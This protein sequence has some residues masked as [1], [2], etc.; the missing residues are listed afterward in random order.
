MRVGPLVLVRGEVVRRVGRERRRARQAAERRLRGRERGTLHS[1]SSIVRMI[2]AALIDRKGAF[3]PED[4]RCIAGHL[5]R[6][7]G[8]QDLRGGLP[9]HTAGFDLGSWVAEGSRALAA[10]L[11]AE[12]ALALVCANLRTCVFGAEITHAIHRDGA[13]F[14]VD[15]FT[16]AEAADTIAL[17]GTTRRRARA[18]CVV[19]VICGHSG[20]GGV[21]IV[22]SSDL[23]TAGE[24]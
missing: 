22:P 13:T 1:A 8:R 7:D 16:H 3:A 2:A 12:H 20:A 4:E 23:W 19:A 21:L 9:T 14:F 17:I 10:I 6:Y 24:H 11:H 15:T 5:D 18:R